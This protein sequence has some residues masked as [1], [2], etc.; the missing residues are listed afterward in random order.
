MLFSNKEKFKKAVKSKND[1]K[2]EILIFKKYNDKWK[3]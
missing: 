1:Q 2:M 3:S